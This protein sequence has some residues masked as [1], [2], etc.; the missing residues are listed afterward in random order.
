MGLLLVSS[1]QPPPRSPRASRPRPLRRHS[2][3][4][5]MLSR[6]NHHM[7]HKLRNSKTLH[8]NPGSRNFASFRTFGSFPRLAFTSIVRSFVGYVKHLLLVA[9]SLIGPLLF[10]NSINSC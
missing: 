6:G 5:E 8:Y 10:F 3:R 9:P 2:R 7:G 4:N 1:R